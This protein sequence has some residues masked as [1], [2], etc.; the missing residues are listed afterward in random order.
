MFGLGIA[1]Y[2]VALILTG[3]TF[4]GAAAAALGSWLAAFVRPY[5]PGMMLIAVAFAFLFRR[6]KE[7]LSQFAPVTKAVWL[8]GLILASLLFVSKSEEFLNER[9]V[10]TTEGVDAT[11]DELTRRSSQGGSQFT[12]TVI[13]SPVEF[14]VGAFTVLFRPLIV[15]A[16]TSRALLSALEGTLLL[17]FTIYRLPW[18]LAAIKSLRKQPYVMF[19]GVYTVL[20]IIGYS[21]VGNFG[22]LVRQ[23]SL[24]MPLFVLFFCIPPLNR[25]KELAERDALRAGQP[26]ESPAT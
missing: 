19:A 22:L 2:G 20:F 12:P 8:A 11:F 24:L 23:R 5:M 3:S 13:K 14:P 7:H 10:D 25:R 4:K 15:E 6:R 16:H 17:L 9:T 26:V 1:A 21:T 18:I